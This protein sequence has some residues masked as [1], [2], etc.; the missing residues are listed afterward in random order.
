MLNK[1]KIAI[2]VMAKDITEPEL[3]KKYKEEL[4]EYEG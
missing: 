1:G 3:I 2:D 4:G